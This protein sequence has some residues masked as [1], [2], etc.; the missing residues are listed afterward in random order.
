NELFT[1]RI[2]YIAPAVDAT[3]HRVA[4]RGVIENRRR[5]L[6]PDMFARFRVL[7][8]SETES[9]AVPASAIIRD[10]DKTTVWVVQDT[11]HFVR[12]GVAVGMEQGGYVQILS[13]LQQGERVVSEGSLFIT[14]A[15]S[16]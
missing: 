7:T 15:A 1:A 14:N 5:R 4:V 13:G 12:R 9:L 11:N 16:S 8:N 3:T 2:S 10:G 6:K